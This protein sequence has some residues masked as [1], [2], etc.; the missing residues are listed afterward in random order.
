MKESKKD[1]KVYRMKIKNSK[2]PMTGISQISIVQSPAHTVKML[3]FAEGQSKPKPL[4]LSAVD[5]DEQICMCAV[6]V[7]NIPI[8]RQEQGTE[9]ILMADENDIFQ[10]ALKFNKERKNNNV[11]LEHDG[12]LVSGVTM[13]DNFIAN[14]KRGI[15][16][17]DGFKELPYGTWF[18]SYKVENPEI[19]ASIKAGEYGGFSITGLFDLEDM[20]TDM[21]VS[22]E[23]ILDPLELYNELVDLLKDIE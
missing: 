6:L 11:D 18:A 4:K 16:P 14:E 7:P 10:A 21:E 22:E 23:E 8:L 3:T 12:N 17:P 13:M 5:E 1:L 9:Y 20:D 2:D 15:M 19:W